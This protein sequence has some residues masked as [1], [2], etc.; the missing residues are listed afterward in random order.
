MTNPQLIILS[1]LFLICGFLVLQKHILGPFMLKKVHFMPKERVYEEIPDEKAKILFPPMFFEAISELN[2]IGFSL[3]CHLVSNDSGRTRSAI[4]LFVNRDTKTMA[5]MGRVAVRRSVTNRRPVGLLEFNTRL[6]DGT[7]IST[8]NTSTVHVF[9]DLPEKVLTRVPH[10]KDAASLFRVHQYIVRQRHSPAMLT[11]PGTEADS[12]RKE[13]NHSLARQAE[14]GYYFLDESGQN[15][16][17]TWKG[18]FRSSW[19]LLWPTKQILQ[20]RQERE[21]RRMAA[22]AEN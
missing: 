5:F 22:A 3:V 18:A 21:G 14:M 12:F 6:Q 20:R 4:S 2:A 16:R 10:L 8:I 11:E 17:L 15:Y 7:E 1:A 9:Y 19:R 13:I